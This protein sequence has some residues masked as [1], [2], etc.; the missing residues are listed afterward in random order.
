L[1][2]EPIDDKK[3]PEEEGC[4][5]EEIN[6]ISKVIAPQAIASGEAISYLRS[7]FVRQIHS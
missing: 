4:G 2:V 1:V 7:S 3:P 5:E 6:H